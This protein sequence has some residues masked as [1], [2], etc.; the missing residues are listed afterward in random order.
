MAHGLSLAP[1]PPSLQFWRH[2]HPILGLNYKQRKGRSLD[3]LAHDFEKG[4]VRPRLVPYVRKESR[5]G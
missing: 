1:K 2:Q 5:G 4:I 3:D